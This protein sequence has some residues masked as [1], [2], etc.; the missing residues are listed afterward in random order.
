[1]KDK[2]IRFS[3]TGRGTFPVDMLRYDRCFPVGTGQEA[4]Q[5]EY[6]SETTKV[7]L[8]GA[9]CTVGRWLSFGW[10]PRFEGG[11][12]HL[13]RH[14]NSSE[15]AERNFRYGADSDVPIGVCHER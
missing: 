9:H 4:I 1:M 10:V 5:S 7:I 11:A 13:A 2:F 15:E 8:E 6:L 3:V 12:S 14:H